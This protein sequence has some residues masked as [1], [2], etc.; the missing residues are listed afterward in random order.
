[1]AGIK[2]LTLGINTLEAVLLRSAEQREAKNGKSYVLITVS[3][4]LNEE[5]VYVWDT[6]A[7]QFLQAFPV[8]SVLTIR[9]EGKSFNNNVTYS[10]KEIK[11]N[12]AVRAESLI[13]TAPGDPLAKMAFLKE[14]ISRMTR[15]S[16]L[17]KITGYIVNTYEKDLLRWPGAQITHHACIG[18][19]LHHICS[20]LF[21]ADKFIGMYGLNSDLLK[22]GLILHDIGKLHE[23][24]IE[25]LDDFRFTTDGMMFG[26]EILGMEMVNE[27]ARVFGIDSRSEDV[28]R[29]KNIIG[30]HLSKYEGGM[31]PASKEAA[32][33]M[34]IDEIDTR[35]DQMDRA[36]ESTS[37]GET[38]GWI[39]YTEGC[40]IYKPS[41]SSIPRS[42]AIP[43]DM[44][45]DANPGLRVIAA[46]DARAGEDRR[47]LL[48][49]Q[50]EQPIT[51]EEAE[52]AAVLLS[53][54]V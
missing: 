7:Q 17:Q 6:T 16:T 40:V 45:S 31:R 8:N 18:G 44:R 20:M 50:K 15:D 30:C 25:A 48:P 53:K 37:I 13:R 14:T 24:S 43:C 9:V 10:L 42:G 34:L 29:L 22:A 21:T 54:A 33:S 35:M 47:N 23:L 49:N 2:D 36:L 46:E 38:S 4:N 52:D 19:L 5:K 32:V 12:P 3:E 1:M 11:V 27:A 39:P 26:H 41:G 51:K 28:L